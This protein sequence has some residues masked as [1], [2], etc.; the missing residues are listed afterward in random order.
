M[1]QGKFTGVRLHEDAYYLNQIVRFKLNESD[2][3]V[4][5]T[6]I[7]IHFYSDN[8]KYDLDL[9]LGDGT[10]ESPEYHSRIYNVEARH[11][12]LP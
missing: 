12:F 1:K 9:C 4:Y 3:P 7:S 5:A 8:V 11:L 2:K 6:I 10:Q